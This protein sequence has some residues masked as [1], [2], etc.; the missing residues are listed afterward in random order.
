VGPHDAVTALLHYAAKRL[1]FLAPIAL[2]VAT[3]V[4]VLLRLVPGDP[5]QVLAGPEATPDVIAQLRVKFGLNQPVLIQYGFFLG[6]LLHGDLGLSYRSGLTV[7]QE[8]G[9]R[10]LATLILAASAT[11]LAVGVGVPL[12]LA[13]GT[14]RDSV[15]DRMAM[16][17]ALVGICAP[18][19]WIGLVLQY[20]IAARF[21]LLP[22]IGGGGMAH[23]I[24]PSVTLG[25]YSLASL[26]RITRA[27]VVNTA[28]RDYVRTARS[29]GLGMPFI[30]RRHILR[31]ALLPILTSIGLEFGFLMTGAVVVETVFAYPGIGV[32]LVQSILSRDYALVQGLVLFIA[33]SYV[34]VN[35]LT[36]LLY[37][38]TDPRVSYQ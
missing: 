2:G 9:H 3:V 31:N 34:L 38:L 15:R 32:L 13:A 8:I 5:A 33:L 24:L 17:V 21:N 36:D 4:F 1:L 10:Y 29:K 28:Q 19:F 16:L 27:A 11:A 7:T 6:R 18:S 37:A 14:H 12:G 25:L 23:L 26:A 30:I 35:L 22:M 20:W